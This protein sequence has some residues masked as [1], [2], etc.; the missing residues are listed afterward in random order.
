MAIGTLAAITTL[1]RVM[2]GVAAGTRCWWFAQRHVLQVTI[3]ALEGRVRALQCKSGFNPMVK[4]SLLPSRHRVTGCAIVATTSLMT[5]IAPVAANTLTRRSLIAG[6]TMTSCTTGRPMCP[7][8][9]KIGGQIM[10]E[11]RVLPAICS[12][13]RFAL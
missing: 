5:V 11:R 4:G 13:T 3:A 8:E 2:T 1:M 9:H 10:I 6:I 12:M 7:L